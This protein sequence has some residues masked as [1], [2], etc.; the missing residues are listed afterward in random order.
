MALDTLESYL[1]TFKFY[2]IWTAVGVDEAMLKLK[3]KTVSL[4]ITGWKMQPI[5]GLQLVEMVRRRD[6]LKE[7]PV[8][9]IAE[10]RDK[11]METTGLKAGAN[12]VLNHPLNAKKLQDTVTELLAD[13][14]D[15]TEERFMEQMDLARKAERKKDLPEAEE[16][17]REALGLKEDETAL[18]ALGRVLR[19]LGKSDE[20]IKSFFAVLRANPDHLKAYLELA[21]V[22]RQLSEL[23]DALKVVKAALKAADRIKEGGFTKASLFYYMGEIELQLKNLQQA[24]GHFRDATDQVPDD[25]GMATQV[26]DALAKEGHYA[27]SEEFYQKAL[28][29]DPSLAHVYNRLGIAHRKQGKM[30]MALNLY[31][32]ALAFHPKDENL[33]YNMARCHWEMGEKQLASEVLTNALEINPEFDEARML[34]NA[35]LKQ[36]GVEANGDGAAVA[37]QPEA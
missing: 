27:E 33:M 7:V 14:I 16:A 5:S 12:A 6:D 19:K 18:M 1:E 22:Y 3:D 37:P 2:R 31:K 32:K 36:I 17:Y 10:Q 30:D 26:G 21:M 8:V 20:A 15:E 11:Q 25:T 23:E 24:L 29:M 13:Q 9:L 28:E 34:L 35:V 4:I